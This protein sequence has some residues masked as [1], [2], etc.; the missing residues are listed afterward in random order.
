MEGGG[1]KERSTV[2]IAS[3]LNGDVGGLGSMMVKARVKKK[4][5]LIIHFDLKLIHYTF[6]SKLLISLSLTIRNLN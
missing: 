2:V 4:M 5:S 3:L 6:G 1:G